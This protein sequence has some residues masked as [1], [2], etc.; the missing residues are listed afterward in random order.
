MAEAP[1]ALDMLNLFTV[2]Q[3]S[4][5]EN[6]RSTGPHC[7][8]PW[9]ITE[10]LLFLECASAV[11]QGINWA[12]FFL[13]I[14][15]FPALAWRIWAQT[16]LFCLFLVF[17]SAC[18]FFPLIRSLYSTADKKVAVF[19]VPDFNNNNDDNVSTVWYSLCLDSYHRTASIMD[20]FVTLVC[21]IYKKNP[22][23]PTHPHLPCTPSVLKYI[24]YDCTHIIQ[25]I[26]WNIYDC[27]QKHTYTVYIMETEVK[28]FCIFC[29]FV[30]LSN[31]DV[32][33]FRP[34]VCYCNTFTEKKKKKIKKLLL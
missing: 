4:C 2:A 19:I 5:T 20:C 34:K 29:L 12:L 3:Q 10:D 17:S 9:C 6:S 24:L 16:E 23:G 13:D 27:I 11:R 22:S 30:Y 14:L 32:I 7:L 15:M 25:H 1:L 26:Y 18:Y 21:F 31:C 28:L 8:A 33:G